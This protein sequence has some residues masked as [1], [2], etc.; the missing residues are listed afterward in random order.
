MMRKYFILGFFSLFLAVIAHTENS[1]IPEAKAQ[2]T[3][4][5][6]V[7]A[8]SCPQPPQT[9]FCQKPFEVTVNT[10]G[11]LRAQYLIKIVD[12]PLGPHCSSIRVHFHVDGV[13]KYTSPF[14]GWPGAPA[15]FDTLP[16]QTPEINLGP[17][18]Q[19]RHKLAIYAEGQVSGC[20]PGWLA[21]WGGD[22]VNITPPP[23]PSCEGFEREC[24]AGFGPGSGTQFCKPGIVENGKCVESDETRCYLDPSSNVEGCKEKVVTATCSNFAPQGLQNTGEIGPG[25]AQIFRAT[26][27]TEPTRYRLSVTKNPSRATFDR[28]VVTANPVGG[29]SPGPAIEVEEVFGGG[30]R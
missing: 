24:D 2:E 21:S 7:F 15:P 29:S 19:G 4:A 12:I 13:R 27:I 18:S 5:V 1:L 26:N 28:P 3:T 6:E 8:I 20:N 11:V 23:A 10:T 9:Q 25:G 17:V 30:G 16:L 14:L 22:I